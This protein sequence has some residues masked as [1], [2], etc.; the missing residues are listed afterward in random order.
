MTK[1]LVSVIVPVYNGEAFLAAAL[2]S[3]FDQ[4]YT[5]HEI[6]VVDDGSTDRS[7]DIAQSF[8]H[9]HYI[10]QQNAGVAA[11]RNTALGIVKGVLIAFLDQDD[12]WVANKLEL[13]VQYLIDHPDMDYVMAKQRID[14]AEDM[15]RPTWINEETIQEDRHAP[16][17]GT[18]LVRREVFDRVGLYDTSY[19]NGSDTDW[20]YRANDLGVKLGQVEATLLIKGVHAD[21][22]SHATQINRDEIFRALRSSVIRKRRS[23]SDA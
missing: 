15:A 5:N 19:R 21:N 1:P 22:E 13:Q 18:L 7:A 11:A 20:V 23:I 17:P 4:S 2:Q 14:L 8:Q 10:Y 6:I 12:Q 3:I 9:I 16:L